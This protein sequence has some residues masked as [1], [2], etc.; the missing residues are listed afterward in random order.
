MA[1]VDNTYFGS[2]IGKSRFF[3]SVGYFIGDKKKHGS[4]ANMRYAPEI[5]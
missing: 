5:G 2:L 4:N 1:L 3:F